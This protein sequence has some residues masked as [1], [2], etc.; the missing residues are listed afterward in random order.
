MVSRDRLNSI[1]S[2]DDLYTVHTQTGDIYTG[3]GKRT[4]LFLYCSLSLFPSLSLFIS[5]SLS[6]S[7][8]QIYCSIIH[9]RII[10]KM[11]F[12]NR[13]FI[14]FSPLG[15]FKRKKYSDLK[16]SLTIVLIYNNKEFICVCYIRIM[17]YCMSKLS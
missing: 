11:H 4:L 6:L 12:S 7:L 1:E 8:T 3:T 15:K 10:D 14:H 17:P 5:L 9:H 2:E 13:L 16:K